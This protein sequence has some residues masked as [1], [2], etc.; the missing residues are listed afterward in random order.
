MS[1]Q[2]HPPADILKMKDSYRY[3]S[4]S[5]KDFEITHAK[6]IFLSIFCSYFL[7]MIKQKTYN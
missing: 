7:K 3:F 1:L 6:A 4:L 2:N 5:T